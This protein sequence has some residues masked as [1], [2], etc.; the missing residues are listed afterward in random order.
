MSHTIELRKV[1]KYYAGEDSVSMGF[2]RIDLD[3]DIGEFVIDGRTCAQ[4]HGC[5]SE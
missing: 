2:S 3:L 4:A 1:S 5:D